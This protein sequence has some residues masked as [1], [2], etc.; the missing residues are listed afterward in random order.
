M[1]QL[2]WKTGCM[3]SGKTLQLLATKHNY[4]QYGRHCIIMSP[5]LDT[6][7]GEGHVSS[8]VAGMD[9]PAVPISKDMDIYHYVA[10]LDYKP[11]AILID[12][13]QFLQVDQVDQL[14]NIVD[15]LAIPVIAFGLRSNF[16]GEL[17]DASKRLYELADKLEEV[18]TIC[19]YCNR[20]AIMNGL[21]EDGKLVTEGSTIHVGDKAYKP[22]CRYHYKKFRGEY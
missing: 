14:A 12:E 8:R 5:T 17:F 13:A 9:E 11:D 3:D 1:A 21:F 7:S 22:L 18:K 19:A 20:K 2:F 15:I 6:R 16:K 4:D 10:T